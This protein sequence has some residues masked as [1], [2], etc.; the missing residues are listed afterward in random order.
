MDLGS[1]ARSQ[2][3]RAR[4][5]LK[6]Y[7][8]YYYHYYYYYCFI[9]IIIIIMIIIIIN[10]TNNPRW[11]Y[12]CCSSSSPFL[13]WR[14]PVPAEGMINKLIMYSAGSELIKYKAQLSREVFRDREK[15]SLR[16]VDPKH[17]GDSLW[18]WDFHPLT[19]RSWL[20]RTLW[21]PESECGDWPKSASRFRESQDL[22][23][24]WPWNG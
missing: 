4:S 18:T 16:F 19:V 6:L 10:N 5:P 24:Q 3:A 11:Y 1:A 22:M 13:H 14:R 20:S 9:V 2:R 15:L 7:C 17:P 8:Y 23:I 21:D 12:S